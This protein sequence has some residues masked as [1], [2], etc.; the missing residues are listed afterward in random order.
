[1]R[2]PRRSSSRYLNLAFNARDAMT[3]GGKLKISASNVILNGQPEGLRGEHV[4]LAHRRQR[5]GHELRNDE[6]RVRAVLHHQGLRRR[7]RPRASAR[8]SASSS[9]SA[10]RSPSSPNRA[11]ARRSPST[12]RR[13]A[14]RVAGGINAQG[15]HGHDR[16][17]V[18]EDDHLV[19]RACGGNAQRTRL[20]SDRHPQRKGG[21]R[22]AVR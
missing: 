11:R 9:K 6:P 17:L 18:V 10:A 8:C 12:C 7:D 14:A 19:V 2:T 21:T 5:R 20:R 3:D 4:A 1:M 13:A 15:P 16:V 22:A